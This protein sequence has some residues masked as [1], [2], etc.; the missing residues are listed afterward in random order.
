M[1]R[2]G[3]TTHL[4][5]DHLSLLPPFLCSSIFFIYSPARVSPFAVCLLSSSSFHVDCLSLSRCSWEQLIAPRAL[6]YSPP[7]LFDRMPILADTPF[8]QSM[9]GVA[10]QLS[11]ELTA[12][13]GRCGVIKSSQGACYSYILKFSCAL[14]LGGVFFLG[15]EKHIY[16][17]RRACC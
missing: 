4:G 3:I 1:D 6:P 15:V 16:I 8:K 2:W 10:K 17:K 5:N 9:A 11:A 7:I 13:A 14:Y 12:Q